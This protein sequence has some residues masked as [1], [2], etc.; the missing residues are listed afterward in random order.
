MVWSCFSKHEHDKN[1]RK[2]WFPRDKL[3]VT[4]HFIHNVIQTFKNDAWRSTT[5][6]TRAE[7]DDTLT[8]LPFP[9]WNKER[10][11]EQTVREI[12]KTVCTDSAKHSHEWCVNTGRMILTDVWRKC[13]H[14]TSDSSNLLMS[15]FYTLWTI[16]D[17][18][19]SSWDC[20]Q[21]PPDVRRRSWS[22]L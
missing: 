2:S 7:D 4:H 19:S 14:D 20:F 13:F 17:S 5:T 6:Q 12:I 11:K 10:N 9:R 22:T 15:R 16:W 8:S 18:S 3:S 1:V 21:I